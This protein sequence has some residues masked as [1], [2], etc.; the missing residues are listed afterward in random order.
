MSDDTSTTQPADAAPELVPVAAQKAAGVP[1]DQ[2]VTI[3]DQRAGTPAPELPAEA[4][5]EIR[6]PF[7]IADV[8]LPVGTEMG[9]ESLGARAFNPGDHVS[10]E[11]VQ[12]YGWEQYVHAPDGDWTVTPEPDDEAGSSGTDKE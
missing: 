7:W 11:H 9:G 8:P 10:P 4:E 2:V 5:P 6:P 1:A 12:Q 3:A